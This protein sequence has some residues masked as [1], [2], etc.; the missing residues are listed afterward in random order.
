[1]FASKVV[2]SGAGAFLGGQSNRGRNGRATS[3]CWLRAAAVVACALMFAR[4]SAANVVIN[5]VIAENDSESPSGTETPDLIELYNTGDAPIVLGA[6]SIAGSY[7]LSD[8]QPAGPGE[9]VVFD[10][11]DSW[12]FP[13]GATIEPGDFLLIFCDE[14]VD[15][16]CEIHA[17]F[18]IDAG[19]NEPLSL[20]GPEVD[21]VRELID[22]VYL[23]PLRRNV[24][25]AR[26]P[27]GA[28][29][30][31]VPIADTLDVFS[32]HPPGT[33]TF[34]Q[35]TT[36]SP[37]TTCANF[38][39]VQDCRGAPN[40][41]GGNLE[42][43]VERQSVSTNRPG[44]GEPV[45]VVARVNDDKRPDE[46]NIVS[47]EI[48]YSV[49]GVEQAPVAMDFIEV[50]DGSQRT[51]P[52]PLDIWSDW[53]ADIPGQPAGARVAFELYVEDAE[54]LSSAAPSRPLSRRHGAV[55]QHRIARTWMRRTT[56]G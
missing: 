23:P 39:V 7:F 45:T 48:R 14:D 55:Q 29:P 54:G 21:G 31:P 38:M 51:P 36:A 52:R 34:G 16:T 17:N 6:E 18:Q 15:D 9:D 8:T 41:P 28:G 50:A 56:T 10:I 5:E 2:S 26:F 40:A 33:A 27:D 1:M 13:P 47:V 53:Q 4:W 20:W 24:T 32:F 12:R 49:D 3:P 22:Q 25:F 46:S 30:A 35:C 44:A 42:P 43:R 37:A 19:G 11:N